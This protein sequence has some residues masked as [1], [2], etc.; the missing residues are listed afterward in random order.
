MNDAKEFYSEHKEKFYFCGTIL[1]LCSDMSHVLI[2][3]GDDAIKRV[4]KLNGPTK[5]DE[6]PPGTIRQDFRSAGGPF[7]TVHSSDS[8]ES[9]EREYMIVRAVLKRSEW[10]ELFGSYYRHRGFVPCG[11]FLF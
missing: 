8:Q 10:S 3:R 1:S 4:R 7:N 5:P 11:D 9:F 2:L 6:A